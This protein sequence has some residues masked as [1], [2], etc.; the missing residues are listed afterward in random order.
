MR[1]SEDAKGFVLAESR[2]PFIPWGFN[3]DHEGDGEL[4][5]DYWDDKWPTVESAFREMKEL[6]A[7]VVRIHLQF[8]KFME[9]PTKPRQHSLDQ[10]ARLV[11][12]AEQTELYIDLTGLG[13]YHKQD[14]PEWYDKL[15]E[16]DRWAAQAVFWE[17]VAK[18]C[19]D[20]PAIFCYDL[21]NEPVVPGGDKKRDDWLGPGFGD[22][23]FVQFIALDRKD[24]NRPDVARKWI[25]TLVDG[26]PQA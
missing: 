9:S 6:G 17:A 18:T 13:C 4:L 26:D 23:H 16:Q 24:R 19:A 25:R 21:M 14:V 2:R 12:L 7:N 5:E 10:L 11:R 15:P 22:K 20:S 3:Y 8:G 1:V